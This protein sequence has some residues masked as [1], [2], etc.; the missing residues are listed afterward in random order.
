MKRIRI[1]EGETAEVLESK[2][3]KILEEI[4]SE[5]VD[6]KYMLPENTIVIEFEIKEPWKNSICC[7]CQYWDDCGSTGTSGICHETGK[8]IR[9]NCRA[10]VQYKDIRG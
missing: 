9:F 7:E 1:V 4:K 10:C 3:N 8:R 5:E 6:I 2:A